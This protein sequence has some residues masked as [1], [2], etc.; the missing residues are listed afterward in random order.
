MRNISSGRYHF[1]LLLESTRSDRYF[2]FIF[3]F[4]IFSWRL[5]R[6]RQIRSLQNRLLQSQLYPYRSLQFPASLLWAIQL[7]VSRFLE[8]SWSPNEKG[9]PYNNRFFSVPER[10]TWGSSQICQSPKKP[11]TQKI[12][13]QMRCCPILEWPSNV[14]KLIPSTV[15]VREVV[16]DHVREVVLEV[17]LLIAILVRLFFTSR[18]LFS[19]VPSI[20]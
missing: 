17:V 13:K 1:I 7:K 20:F 3:R 14:W 15:H 6:N 12:P 8:L 18:L 9:E 10:E 2:F 16:R 19:L 5:S 4:L 11:Q